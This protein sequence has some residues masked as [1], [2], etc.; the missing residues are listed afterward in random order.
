MSDECQQQ[1]RSNNSGV[2]D[3]GGSRCSEQEKI[4]NGYLSLWTEV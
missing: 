4:T 2:G 3:D 1:P